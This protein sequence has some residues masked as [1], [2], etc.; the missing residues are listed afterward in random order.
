MVSI[1]VTI[2]KLYEM[3][4]KQALQSGA[5][6]ERRLHHFLCTKPMGNLTTG[7]NSFYTSEQGEILC[8]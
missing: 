2:K 6:N 1:I 7:N 4:T 5:Y 3:N 8:G